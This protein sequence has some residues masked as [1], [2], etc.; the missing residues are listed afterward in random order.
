MLVALTVLPHGSYSTA[1]PWLREGW[2][3]EAYPLNRTLHDSEP[4]MNFYQ[5]GLSGSLEG[6]TLLALFS[7]LPLHPN[8]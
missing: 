8:R 5:R 6:R 7:P 1:A 2:L 4:L 3:A